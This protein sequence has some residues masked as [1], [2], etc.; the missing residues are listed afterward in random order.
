MSRFHYVLLALLTAYTM[1]GYSFG[2]YLL[3]LL[4]PDMIDDGVISYQGLAAMTAL[5][6]FGFLFIS[7]LSGRL[8]R[9][10]SPRTLVLGSVVLTGL[11]LIVLASVREEWIIIAVVGL[12]GVLTA[13]GWIPVV[14]VVQESIGERY[15]GLGIALAG[16]GTAHGIVVTGLCVP[17]IM[18]FFDWP[19][20]WLLFGIAAIVMAL[21]G[22]FVIPAVPR[23]A[24]RTPGSSGAGI[25]EH[26]RQFRAYFLMMFLSGGAAMGYITYIV[27]YLRDDL[28]L[29][30]SYAGMTWSILGV[31]GMGSGIAWGRL[32]DVFSQRTALLWGHVVLLFAYGLVPIWSDPT[33]ALVSAV[34]FGVSFFGVMPLFGSYASKAVPSDEV[35]SL[36]GKGNF[37]LGLGGTVFNFL[38]GNIKS[39]TGSFDLLFALTALA[40]LATIYLCRH[41]PEG[42]A[43]TA[44]I[45]EP[46]G[47]SGFGRQA[48]QSGARASTASRSSAD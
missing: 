6:Q 39:L 28:A 18:M 40:A 9:A 45:R 26:I 13:T 25:L 20:V 15:W 8:T 43:A 7:L 41:L 1:V 17:L 32:A 11:G 42:A 3:S 30:P 47:A 14:R 33:V 10:V 16:S 46:A 21:G 36:Y 4:A 34:L 44:V 5:N 29:S 37:C 35:I 12:L 24:K 19:N 38:G 23:D 2:R 31:V 48:G 27:P 22:A